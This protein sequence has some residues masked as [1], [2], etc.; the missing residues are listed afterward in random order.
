VIFVVIRLPEF[1]QT[2][3]KLKSSQFS[4]RTILLGVTAIGATLAIA[5]S[6]NQFVRLAALSVLAANL[7]GV[8]VGL[9]VTHLFKMPRDGGYRHHDESHD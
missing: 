1:F 3:N 5:T 2:V 6:S 9:I 7:F 8:F 4:L